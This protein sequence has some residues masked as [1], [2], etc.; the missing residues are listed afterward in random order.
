MNI[1]YSVVIPVHN[2]EGNIEKLTKAIYNVL[3]VPVNYEVIYVDDASEDKSKELLQRLSKE[4]KNLRAISLKKR[5][6]QS[7]ALYVG[8]KHCKGEIIITLDGDL[9]NPPQE[10]HKLLD[11]LNKGYDFVIGIRKN[12][13]DKIIK[14]ISSKIANWYR[15][16][17][18]GDIFLDIGCSLR[19]FRREVL[20]CIF[21][22][23]S[24]HRFLPYLA[25]INKFKVSQ[26]E[27]EHNPRMYGKTKYG[28]GKR[29]LDGLDDLKGMK[30]LK[31]RKIAYKELFDE[32]NIEFI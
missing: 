5:Y 23:K 3:G 12:R 25:L 30:W 28:I 2:E 16:I 11:E 10:I 31:H 1:I 27:V 24:L 17:T 18:L 21:P 29:L 7:G 14:R 19:V 20:N 26:V 13:Q 6:G 32:S 22:F 9:Q 8:L 4:Y 15:R